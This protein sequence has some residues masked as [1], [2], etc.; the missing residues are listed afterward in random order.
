MFLPSFVDKIFDNIE[1]Q[2]NTSLLQFLCSTLEESLNEEWRGHSATL[3]ARVVC[4]LTLMVSDSSILM[5]FSG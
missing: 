3:R 2:L 5:V 4:F 1:C